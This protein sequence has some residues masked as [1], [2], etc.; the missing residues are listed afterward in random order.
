MEKYQVKLSV[1]LDSLEYCS[2]VEKDGFYVIKG[3]NEIIGYGEDLSEDYSYEDEVWK[4]LELNECLHLPTYHDIDNLQPDWG[5]YITLKY[6]DVMIG[7]EK[8]KKSLSKAYNSIF[9]NDVL[10]AIPGSTKFC[11]E[12]GKQKRMEEW[13]QFV[14]EEYKAHRVQFVTTWCQEH[15]VEIIYDK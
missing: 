12:L 14:M 15:D 11:K 6:I 5:R 10:P 9:F 8:Q 1:L 4:F 13:D 2:D 3:T 7:D